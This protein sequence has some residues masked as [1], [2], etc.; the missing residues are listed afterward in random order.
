MSY[1]RALLGT[2]PLPR[3]RKLAGATLYTPYHVVT[4]A[5]CAVLVW[6]AP[7]AWELTQRLTAPRAAVPGGARGVAAD[8]VDPDRQPVSL[9]PVLME[10][11]TA[12]LNESEER[13]QRELASTE[14][15]PRVARAMSLAFVALVAVVPL[16]QAAIEL[17]AT[18]GCRR[19]T[20]SPAARRGR[21]CTRL[22]RRSKAA[23]R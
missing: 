18:A 13:S 23:Q 10:T 19:S 14:V 9:L 16:T 12:R 5:L 2:V 15:S 4:F 11:Q 6:G 1:L 22:N 17:R 3:R 7:Q 21:R 20:C 8:D